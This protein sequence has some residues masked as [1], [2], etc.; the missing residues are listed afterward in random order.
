MAA[1]STVTVSVQL[2]ESTSALLAP[3]DALVLQSSPSAAPTIPQRILVSRRIRPVR[4]HSCADVKTFIESNALTA[5]MLAD[6]ATFAEPA[7][8]FTEPTESSG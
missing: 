6:P 4:R 3:F 7:E 1:N 8:T 2:P 5:A